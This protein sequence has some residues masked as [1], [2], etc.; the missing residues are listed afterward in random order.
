[1]ARSQAGTKPIRVRK[2]G[3]RQML[4]YLDPAL[5]KTLKKTALDRDVNLYDIVDE[6][7]RDW[8]K[9]IKAR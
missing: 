7:T 9:K 5:I 1:M 2:D 8:L 6:A 4:V 3:K